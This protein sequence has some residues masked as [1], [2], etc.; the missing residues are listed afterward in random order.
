MN[1]AGGTQGTSPVSEVGS[2][3][4]VAIGGIG[5]SGTRLVAELLIRLGI[6]MGGDLNG[7][8][9]NLWYTLLFKRRE[10]VDGDRHDELRHAFAIFRAVMVER[11]ILTNDEESY[12]RS[13]AAEDR[14]PHTAEWLRERAASLT[15]F[16]R[17]HRAHPGAW[18]WKEPNTHV[19]APLFTST[20]PELRYIH[21]VRNGLDMAY[22]SNLNQ[23]HMWGSFILQEIDIEPSPRLALKFWCAVH[24]RILELGTLMGDRF[25]LLDYDQLCRQPDQGLSEIVEFLGTSIGRST[26]SVL[27]DAVRPP[28]SVGR[29]RDHDIGEL[30]PEDVDFVEEMGF[31][32]S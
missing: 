13:L 15:A 6:F 17:S 20:F 24:R 10:L 4:P 22:S 16:P 9:D 19:L 2:Q 23:L 30:D 1:L 25:L 3:P 27:L 32:T 18:G 12:V 31:P 21:V 8:N 11:R 5:G 26:R 14:P 28:A 29:F 7:A